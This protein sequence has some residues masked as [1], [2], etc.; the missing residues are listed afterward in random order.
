VGSLDYVGVLGDYRRYF[1]P[2]RPFTLAARLLHYGRYRSDGE[3]PRLQP[4][5]LGYAGLVRGYNFGS[6]DPSECKPG[7]GDDPDSCP[8]F[9]Q[10]LGSRIVVGSVELR[11]PLLGM[12]GVGSGYYGAFPI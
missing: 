10:L 4:L 8:V 11:F 5:Y 2:A 6:F 1:M 12:L 3:D 9:D 7:P